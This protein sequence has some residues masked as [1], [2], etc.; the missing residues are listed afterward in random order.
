M[1]IKIAKVEWLDAWTNNGWKGGREQASETHT[2]IK[3]V[4]VGIIAINDKTGITLC[5]GMAEDGNMLSMQF[6]PKKMIKKITIF[7]ETKSGST[8][9]S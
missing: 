6:I 4:N 7:K 8:R 9:R 1:K 5:S 2:P 3:V